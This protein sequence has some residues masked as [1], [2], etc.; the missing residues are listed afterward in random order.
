MDAPSTVGPFDSPDAGRRWLAGR[1]DLLA[2]QVGQGPVGSRT[3]VSSHL[4]PSWTG[5]GCSELVD[6]RAYS[7]TLKL[8]VDFA[9][10]CEL[11]LLAVD[12]MLL[13]ALGH[14]SQRRMLRMLHLSAVAL[15][16]WGA[17]LVLLGAFSQEAGMGVAVAA[18]MWAVSVLVWT[19]CLL[20]IHHR[21]E[22]TADD[23]ALAHGGVRPILAHLRRSGAQERLERMQRRIWSDSTLGD[24][25]DTA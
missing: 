24:R 9:A 1:A 21:L 8:R 25:D 22:S 7:D 5:G 19:A 17:V 13:H 18:G 6:Y 3:H 2:A 4:P 16:A 14:R 20:R 11:D 15:S 23:F 10:A 12:G